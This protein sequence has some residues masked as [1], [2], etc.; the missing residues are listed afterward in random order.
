[1]TNFTTPEAISGISMLVALCAVIVGPIVT[2]KVA[3]RQVI[4]PMRQ[5]WIDELRELM[6][7][8]LSE[9]R[10][11]IVLSEGNGLLNAGKTDE[12][13]FQKLLYL[14]QKLRLMLNQN[15]DDH[16]ELLKLVHEITEDVQHG[17]GNLINFGS[18]LTEA[19]KLCQKIL[20]HEWERVKNGG[21]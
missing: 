11:V 15:E 8:L 17:G 18:R 10:K 7:Q 3:K 1:M 19:T 13:A 21:L 2:F 12:S 5:K 9:S 16:S 20:K 14:E 4:S 6:S